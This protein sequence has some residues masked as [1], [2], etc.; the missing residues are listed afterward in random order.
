MVIFK[1]IIT[2]L[3]E[4]LDNDFF[5][6]DIN[7]DISEKQWRWCHVI[8]E[9]CSHAEDKYSM[10]NSLCKFFQERISKYT[11][12]GKYR[13]DGLNN[14]YHIHQPQRNEE[15]QIN[16]IICLGDIIAKGTHQQEC[17]ELIKNN[18]DIVLK[19]NFDEYFT[20]D[21]DLSTKSKQEVDRII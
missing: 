10:R 6:P 13:I 11:K 20:S 4:K 1:M 16:K 21:I 9:K 3:E 12:I 15:K 2:D 17:V 7:G 8:W 14:Q 5:I 19:E 18:C